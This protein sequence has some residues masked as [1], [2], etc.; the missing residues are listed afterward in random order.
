MARH[1]RGQCWKNSSEVSIG[2]RP[3]EDRLSLHRVIRTNLKSPVVLLKEASRS[4]ACMS[5]NP[6]HP[7]RVGVAEIKNTVET[8]LKCSRQ[9]LWEN[10]DPHFEFTITGTGFLGR[11]KGRHFFITAKHCLDGYE[12]NQLRVEIVPGSGI[13]DAR[14]TLHVL[15][16]K[17]P[18]QDLAVIEFDP[19]LNPK[20]RLG[21]ADFLD[22]DYFATLPAVHLAGWVFAFRGY[23]AEKNTP[24]WDNKVLKNTTI[25]V[26]GHWSGKHV[27]PNTG[28]F[29]LSAPVSELGIAD[30][31]GSSGSPVFELFSKTDG[32]A[33]KLAGVLVWEQGGIVR[34]IE[35]YILF[36]FL[37]K[38]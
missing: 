32:V 38:I 6:K 11:F 22:L 20:E 26:D 1:G 36:E 35:A 5:G 23:P 2:R 16:G 37:K 34:F 31:D 21:S 13:F 7:C 33:Y 17:E 28:T 4:R 24:D 9:L 25:S 3:S 29:E 8:L 18:Y 14:K 19:D 15:Q 10:D 12:I 30:I 27:K